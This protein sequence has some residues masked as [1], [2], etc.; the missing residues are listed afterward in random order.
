MTRTQINIHLSRHET[1]DSIDQLLGKLRA[2]VEA[3]RANPNT[4]TEQW[5]TLRAQWQQLRDAIGD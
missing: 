1:S 4:T 3:A 2:C 5:G